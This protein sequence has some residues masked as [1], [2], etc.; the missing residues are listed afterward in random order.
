MFLLTPLAAAPIAALAG[1]SDPS[2]LMYS[3]SCSTPSA[4]T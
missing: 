4:D 1:A 3:T 2:D